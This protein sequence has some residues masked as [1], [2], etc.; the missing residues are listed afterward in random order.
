VTCVRS[1]RESLS[2]PWRDLSSN[3]P[4][5]GTYSS[6]RWARLGNVAGLF[7]VAPVGAGRLYGPWVTLT[8]TEVSNVSSSAPDAEPDLT[9]SIVDAICNN[10]R[11]TAAS[12]PRQGRLKIA[13]YAERSSRCERDDPIKCRVKGKKEENPSP[14]R[15]G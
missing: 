11:M 8:F 14:G 3:L 15:D 6:A 1:S 12:K 4:L 7:S 2:R 5:P 10:R 13:R 9:R